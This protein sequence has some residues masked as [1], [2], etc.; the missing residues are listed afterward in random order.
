MSSG[1]LKEQDLIQ[2]MRNMVKIADDLKTAFS[3]VEPSME[4]I[5]SLRDQFEELSTETIQIVNDYKESVDSEKQRSDEILT[6][7]QEQVQRV[8]EDI[9]RLLSFEESFQEIA[10]KVD[11]VLAMKDQLDL[12]LQKIED[13]TSLIV[14]DKD[15]YIEPEDRQPNKFYIN[16]TD[17]MRTITTGDSVVVSPTISMKIENQLITNKNIKERRA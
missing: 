4:T 12:L 3:Q 9:D 15:S 14:M 16:I 1:Y 10:D 11:Q 5:F 7:A 8:R 17:E 13:A 2:N 6:E